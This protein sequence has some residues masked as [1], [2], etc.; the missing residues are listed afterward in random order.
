VKRGGMSSEL[1]RAGS[2]ARAVERA[3]RVAAVVDVGWV[4][5]TRPFSVRGVSSRI[6][7]I[8]KRRCGFGGVA[9]GNWFR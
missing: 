1:A 5:R 3:A 4:G 8:G 7:I 2:G 9:G 6:G